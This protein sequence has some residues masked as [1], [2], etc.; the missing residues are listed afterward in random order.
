MKKALSLLL[1]LAMVLSMVP[2]VFA[3]ETT[4]ETES[5]DAVI[6]TITSVDGLTIAAGASAE[7]TFAPTESCR[8]H[9]EMTGDAAVSVDG[10]VVM[11]PVIETLVPDSENYEGDPDIYLEGVTGE[12]TL[13]V[14]AGYT[15]AIVLT[16]GNYDS[17]ITVADITYPGEVEGYPYDLSNEWVW[18]DA[19]TEATATVNVAA[20]ETFYLSSY[21]IGGM[22]MSINGGEGVTCSGNP[23][24][25]YAWSI[26]NDGTEAA[27]YVITV[28]YALGSYSNPEALTVSK[29]AAASA[30]AVVAADS[31]G[32]YYNVTPADDGYV[33]IESANTLAVFNV[34]GTNCES[35]YTVA[36]TADV[37]ISVNVGTS[38]YSAAEVAFTVTYVSDEVAAEIAAAEAV[39]EQINDL[40]TYNWDTWENEL[41]GTEDE[42]KAAQ[43]AYEALSDTAKAYIDEDTKTKLDNAVAT[44]P[45]Y[46]PYEV[47][48]S[49]IT[50]DMAAELFIAAKF[51]FPDE[52]MADNNA[53]LT[54]EFKGD[55]T[56]YNLVAL[57]E[58]LGLDSKGRLVLKQPIPSPYMDKKLTITVTDGNG[59]AA[60]FTSGGVAYE[61]S[62]SYGI[63]EYADAICNLESM[64]TTM[65]AIAALLTYGSYA[66]VKFSSLPNVST[67]PAYNLLSKYGYEPIDISGL[68]VADVTQTL[69]NS[70]D[71]IGVTIRG[72]T[73]ALDAAVYMTVQFNYDQTYAVED[74]TFTVKYYEAASGK[75]Y[76]IPVE[77]SLNSK[78]RIEIKIENIAAA[79]FDC[80]Y[81]VEVTN[82][83][84]GGV[85]SGQYSIYEYIRATVAAASQVAEADLNL[86]K[87][88]YYYNQAANALFE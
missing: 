39:A 69:V 14:V 1:V 68:T 65:D 86:A 80:I 9:L 54:V 74:Y 25:A 6:E 29:A 75:N 26:T 76:E 72:G 88:M 37:P 49:G 79:L 10:T 48:V 30:T 24:T 33:V 61:G 43:A 18:N 53:T 38:D 78:G 22:I 44:L 52:L 64:K 58:E 27:D 50:L 73:P 55:V 17:T 21:G 12:Y 77:A 7:Y 57:V 19:Y 46:E 41:T 23:R 56:E 63:E 20:G 40:Y 34:D 2:A 60:N 3:E 13:E 31:Q 66:Q 51:L 85:Y 11:D 67:E 5:T 59:Y 83:Q 45:A 35:G 32:Y 84:T 8:L 62:Y 71:S 28:A 81:T 42:I 47:A 16:G 36:V 82:N 4:T 15:Y 87:A 70:G